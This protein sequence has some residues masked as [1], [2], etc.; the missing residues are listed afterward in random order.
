[1]NSSTKTKPI[2]RPKVS[3]GMPVFN[4][5]RFIRKALDSLLSQTHADFELIISDNASTDS[6]AWICEEYSK[7]DK[8]IRYIRQKKNMG[9]FWNVNFVLQE[10]KYKY[11]M[12]AAADD[13]WDP[14]FI[15]KNLN[16]LESNENIVGSISEVQII[17]TMDNSKLNTNYPKSN[18]FVKYKYVHPISGSYEEKVAF[19]L[20]F[21]QNTNAYALFR[22]DKLR[23]CTSHRSQTR[24]DH[25][26]SLNILKYGDIHVIDEVLMY[27]HAKG[28]SS[29]NSIIG[30]MLKLGISFPE[31][32]FLWFPFT[33]WCAK[34]LGMKIF[35]KNIIWFIRLNYCGER[36]ILM[37]SVRL[38]KRIICR[39][40]KFW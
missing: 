26:L 15:E 38:C 22:T 14:H 5:E 32:I 16:V 21:P 39:Q 27:R 3:I 37:E 8:R 28:T 29:M 31:I 18:N 9:I 35:M 17:E 1:M 34:H 25:I 33:F 20:R 13:I 11:F 12:W 7:K 23:K 6:T 10:A 4:G 19:C 24:W 2:N 40:E 36:A 30:R